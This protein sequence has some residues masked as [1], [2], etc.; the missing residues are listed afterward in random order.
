MKK[1]VLIITI[2]LV[3]I[4]VPVFLNIFDIQAK[5]M[6]YSSSFDYQP[7]EGSM[8]DLYQDIFKSLLASYID[9]AICNY[10]GQPFSTEPLLNKVLNIERPNGPGTSLFIIKMRVIPY[11]GAHREVG[12]DHI[13]FRIEVSN[14]IV[15]KFEHIKTFYIPPKP[16]NI[17]S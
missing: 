6:S 1:V 4:L 13:T 9:K 12:I 10:Y 17:P 3:I 15:E 8:E 7:L 11:Y 5:D 14:V 16:K 2:T